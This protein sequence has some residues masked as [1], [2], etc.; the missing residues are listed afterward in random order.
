MVEQPRAGVPAQ[1]AAEDLTRAFDALPEV[2]RVVAVL[3][4]LEGFSYRE[5]ADMLGVPIGTV[6]SRLARGRSLLQQAVWQHSDAGRVRAPRSRAG[7]ER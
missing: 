3:S 1:G 2:F 4:V 6:R 5:I 7:G